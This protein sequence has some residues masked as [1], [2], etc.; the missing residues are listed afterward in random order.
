MGA[1]SESDFPERSVGIQFHGKGHCDLDVSCTKGLR[2]PLNYPKR[3]D[4]PR[5][6]PG[7]R[8]TRRVQQ[9]MREAAPGCCIIGYTDR[10]PCASDDK[11]V[12]T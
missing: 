2:I 1:T 9:G 3:I 8:E 6:N 7:D 10:L 5:T 11:S 12:S 4:H